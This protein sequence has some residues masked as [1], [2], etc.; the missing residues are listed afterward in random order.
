MPFEE[1]LM[2][3]TPMAQPGASLRRTLIVIATLILGHLIVLWAA[4][5]AMAGAISVS[6]SQM[7][8]R[9]VPVATPFVSATSLPRT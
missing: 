2:S 1:T 8:S 6:G 9:T 3:G 5:G 4:A 7:Y